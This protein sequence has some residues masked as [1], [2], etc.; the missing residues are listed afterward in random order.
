MDKGGSIRALSRG[1]AVL[2]AVNR[3]GTMTITEICESCDIAYATASRIAQTLAT[4]GLIARDPGGKRFRATGLVRT[5]AQGY[6]GSGRLVLAARPHIIALTRRI[7]WPVSITTRIGPDMVVQD[8]S[9]SHTTMVFSSPDPGYSL[10]MLECAAGIAYL[11]SLPEEQF[12]DIVSGLRLIDMRHLRHA[13]DRLAEGDLRA[14]VRA[15][16]YATRSNVP[17]TRH[18]GKTS[19]IA[20]PLFDRGQPA[21]AITLIY[22]ASALRMAEAVN[23]FL[24]EL[25]AAASAVEHD[26][27]QLPTL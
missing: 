7:G 16:G 4:E 27:D 26:L 20:L 5:L 22:F 19:G 8:S 1:I 18:P 14:Q 13:L 3:N 17:F 12:Q 15:L 21:G 11:C 6:Q 2:K 10:P 23:R 24:P 25:K 9:H